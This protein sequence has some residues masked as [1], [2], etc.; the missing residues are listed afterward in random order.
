MAKWF[1]DKRGLAV[2]LAVGGYGAGSAI[3]G[4]L[5]S[6]VLIP[7]YGWRGTF[8]ILGVI[9]FLM[10]MVGSFLLR[11]AA[12][13]SPRRVKS[14]SGCDKF[15]YTRF[16]SWRSPPHFQFLLPLARLCIGHIGRTDGH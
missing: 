3:F 8:M 1:P 4:P 16:R 14:S 7:A 10:T 13:L 9:F 5:S 12:C 15:D 2:G 11:P 6:K